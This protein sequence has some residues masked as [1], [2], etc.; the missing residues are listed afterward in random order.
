MKLYYAP[1][2]CSLAP[3][4]VI[5]EAGLEAEMVRVDL[6][7]HRTA[8]G[9]DYFAVNPRGY[10]PAIE[11]GDGSV[12]TEVAALLPWLAQQAPG[13][14][15]VPAAG[16]RERFE[17]DQWL[18]FVSSELHKAFS[19]WLWH[20]DTAASTREAVTARIEGRLDGM[21]RHLS[22]REWLAAG[23]FSVADAYGFTI[24]N[25]APMLGMSLARW[26]NVQAWMTRVASRP[27]VAEALRAE[28]LKPP[29]FAARPAVAA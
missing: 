26:P 29:V 19:P 22:N 7:T 4:I 28:G 21:E 10:V 15:L 14:G 27:A 9:A 6:A 12:H 13:A 24:L 18:V 3:H 16:S 25:W 8:D 11:L 5:R 17:V 23:R 20:K 1:G 2:A